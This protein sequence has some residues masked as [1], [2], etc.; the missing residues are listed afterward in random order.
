MGSFVGSSGVVRGQICRLGGEVGDEEHADSLSDAAV[1]PAVLA[2]R[3]TV[4]YGSLW[5]GGQVGKGPGGSVQMVG[6]PLDLHMV[7]IAVA[8]RRPFS[9]GRR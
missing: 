7:D 1:A 2:Q 6:E 8:I 9:P 3:S 4:D 5:S